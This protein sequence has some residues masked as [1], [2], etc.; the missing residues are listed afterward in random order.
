MYYIFID[1]IQKVFPIVN[2]SLTNSMHIKDKSSD[3]EV[4][5][6]IDVVL[7]LSSIKNVDLYI[8]GSNSKMLSNDIITEFRDRA[9]NINLQPLSFEE[10][11]KYKGED[12]YKVLHDF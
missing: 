6:F 1:E 7:D 2:L 8:T 9:T 5:G 3:K 11:Y 10:F 12:S 4:I